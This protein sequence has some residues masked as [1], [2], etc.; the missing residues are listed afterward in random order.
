MRPSKVKAFRFNVTI[1]YDISEKWEFSH[2][3]ESPVIEE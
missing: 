1:Q 2:S 3:N